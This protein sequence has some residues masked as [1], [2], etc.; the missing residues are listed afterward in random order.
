MIEIMFYGLLP[1]NY[2][3]QWFGTRIVL[4]MDNRQRNGLKSIEWK[5]EEE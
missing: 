3:T 1:I 2:A 4:A 5:K